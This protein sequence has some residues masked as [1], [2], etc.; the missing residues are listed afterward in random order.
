MCPRTKPHLSELGEIVDVWDN[1]KLPAYWYVPQYFASRPEEG[2]L[3]IAVYHCRVLRRGIFGGEMDWVL[4]KL[5]N[6]IHRK[7]EGKRIYVQVARKGCLVSDIL[8][9]SYAS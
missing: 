5:T 1:A 6:V 9:T 4:T 8:S 2:R 7:I 3:P